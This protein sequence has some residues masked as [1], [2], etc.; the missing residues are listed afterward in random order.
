[1]KSVQVPLIVAPLWPSSGRVKRIV[2]HRVIGAGIGIVLEPGSRGHHGEPSP[3]H[4]TRMTFSAVPLVYKASSDCNY[5]SMS[6]N[7][8]QTSKF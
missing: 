6:R 1:M 7:L 5:F 4:A 2:L 8:P 3:K